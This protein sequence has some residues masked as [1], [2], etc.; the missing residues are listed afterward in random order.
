MVKFVTIHN[1]FLLC[2]FLTFR[3]SL[4]VVLLLCSIFIFSSQSSIDFAIHLVRFDFFTLCLFINFTL[5]LFLNSSR[6]M[7]PRVSPVHL[8]QHNLDIDCAFFVHPS[9]GPNFV[10]VSPK[11]NGSNYLV[12]RRS[13]QRAFL[14][15][16]FTSLLVVKMVGILDYLYFALKR[17]L[18]LKLKR[19]IT[20]Q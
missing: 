11:F 10:I 15:F 20:A 12:W 4:C 5:C 18:G 6:V 13:M 9:E 7:P 3:L 17:Q 14:C 8:Q 19:R 1:R 16:H 2:I